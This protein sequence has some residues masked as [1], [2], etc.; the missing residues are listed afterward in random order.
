MVIRQKDYSPQRQALQNRRKAESGFYATEND[1]ITMD[2]QEKSYNAQQAQ[3]GLS[4]ASTISNGIG[5]LS[6]QIGSMVEASDKA[7]FDRTA[8]QAKSELMLYNQQAVENG[9]IYWDVDEEGN[10]S[11]RFSDAYAK[12]AD[13]IYKKYSEM[14]TDHDFGKWKKALRS[15]LQT[16][17]NTFQAGI[18]SS[19][20]EKATNEAKLAANEGYNLA[21]NADVDNAAQLFS[22]GEFVAVGYDSSESR[23]FIDAQPGL[24]AQ[25]KG[26]INARNAA[27]FAQDVT[28][29]AVLKVAEQQGSTAAKAVIAQLGA[30]QL[31]ANAE[32][33][34]SD[35]LAAVDEWEK[36]TLASVASTASADV[37]KARQ[38]AEK[39][40]GYT[41]FSAV[42]VAGGERL[43]GS[44][45]QWQTY[46][47]RVNSLQ[48]AECTEKAEQLIGYVMDNGMT[49]EAC[50][51]ALNELDSDGVRNGLAAGE[52][53]GVLGKTKATLEAY[54]NR[55]QEKVD[56]MTTEV[57]SDGGGVEPYDWT[58]SALTKTAADEM[59]MAVSA[60]ACG[61]TFFAYVRQKDLLDESVLAVGWFEGRSLSDMEQ[62][63]ALVAQNVG[64]EEA[65]GRFLQTPLGKQFEG[66]PYSEAK[67]FAHNWDMHVQ[68]C[69][70]MREA[71]YSKAWSK[72]KDSGLVDNEIMNAV[73]GTYNWVAQTVFG[74]KDITYADAK[75][76]GGAKFLA[77][78]GLCAGL[79]T[80][81]MDAII[82]GATAADVREMLS[83]FMDTLSDKDMLSA[84]TGN[85]AVAGLTSDAF[86]RNN[87]LMVAMGARLGSLGPDGQF[88]TFPELADE[89]EA[90]YQGNK[91]ALREFLSDGDEIIDTPRDVVRIDGQYINTPTM[92]VRKADG[93]MG[94]YA[95][96]DG[97]ELLE[98]RMTADGIKWERTGRTI[99]GGVNANG[100]PPTAEDAAKGMSAD[101]SSYRQGVARKKHLL[102]GDYEMPFKDNGFD[103]PTL[104]E[105]DI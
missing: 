101:E 39:A 77:V 17:G 52:V 105:F 2:M 87:S 97:M 44:P 75:R 67:G 23:K 48:T 100:L 31:G 78:N 47:D 69:D 35:L 70:Y 76:Q 36:G 45:L 12:G 16:E 33:A 6:R 19:L 11:L 88:R 72:M 14:L 58:G 22:S 27:T 55:A 41:D 49:V 10:G 102:K 104:S 68:G 66:L 84:L 9:D 79:Q 21:F 103:I 18:V 91:L 34:R 43:K 71:I 89:E 99:T 94:Y 74:K 98:G 40:G 90:Q 4:I 54:R 25:S 8:A 93:T 63:S 59:D 61:R 83:G 53:T 37:A 38:E 20:S 92:T 60:D 80:K 29:P 26:E 86:S 62:M 56:S 82:N 42:R 13:E 64:S 5:S 73:E 96:D 7:K 3:F 1:R 57:P 85:A 65:W 32:E 28:K 51:W 95:F 30:A 15:S 50:D 81:V 46:M 24:S